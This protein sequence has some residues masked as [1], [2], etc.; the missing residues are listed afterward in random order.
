MLTYADVCRSV[1]ILLSQMSSELFALATEHSGALEALKSELCSEQICRGLN[2]LAAAFE[3]TVQRNMVLENRATLQQASL[4]SSF[5]E[6][7][8]SNSTLRTQVATA[9]LSACVSY[10]LK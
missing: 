4:E 10:V 6:S 7:E 5:A 1:G 2:K 3:A 8:A 9:T